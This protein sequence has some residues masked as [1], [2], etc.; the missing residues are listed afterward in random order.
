[1]KS[2]PLLLICAFAVCGSAQERLDQEDGLSTKGR[3]WSAALGE[4]NSPDDRTAQMRCLKEFPKTV[5]ANRR[6]SVRQATSCKRKPV[7]SLLNYCR[8][9]AIDC[10]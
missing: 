2:A 9:L 7:P 10:A 3:K 1:V 6:R 4:R 5:K 8:Q